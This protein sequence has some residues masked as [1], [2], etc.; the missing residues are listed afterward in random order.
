[1]SGATGGLVTA[2]E[3]T[4]R[5][6]WPHR[7][8][9]EVRLRAAMETLH[10][11]GPALYLEIDSS[12]TLCE[13]A[14]RF[15]RDSAGDWQYSITQKDNPLRTMLEALAGIYV[16]GVDV[17]WAAFHRDNGCR[18]VPLPNYPFQRQRYWFDDPASA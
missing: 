11:Q 13:E 14:V 16:R 4:A 9:R 15:F 17:D 3:F 6:Y 8:R 2:D 7:L 1:M 10:A 18:S 12:G 5:D